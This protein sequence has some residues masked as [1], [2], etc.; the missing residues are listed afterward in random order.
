MAVI[1]R[2]G[3]MVIEEGY[4]ALSREFWTMLE[5]GIDLGTLLQTL[6]SACGNNLAALPS[7]VA[8]VPEAGGIH[9]AVRGAFELA[10]ETDS[11][12]VVMTSGNVITWEE[13]RIDGLTCA[14]KPKIWSLPPPQ[15][16][17]QPTPPWSSPYCALRATPTPRTS[18][19]A[20]SAKVP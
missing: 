15:Q 17:R 9:V 12:T 7:F 10:M 2:N 14:N 6:T 1:T 20:V 11:G 19:P 8:L 18:N 5:G 3:V 13:K 4:G 16:N